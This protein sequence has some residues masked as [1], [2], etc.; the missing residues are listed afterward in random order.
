[1][2]FFPSYHHNTYFRVLVSRK[3]NKNRC[4]YTTIC[5]FRGEFDTRLEKNQFQL[6]LKHRRERE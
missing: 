3:I 1:M 5:F 2:F 6:R 4:K